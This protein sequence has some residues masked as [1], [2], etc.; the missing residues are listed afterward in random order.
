MAKLNG[1]CMCGEVQF[2][3][4]EDQLWS[5][6]CHCDDCRKQTASPFTGFFG[7]AEDDYQWTE[8]KAAVYHSTK[9]VNR[10]FCGKC[11]TPMAFESTNWP[12]EIHFYIA[13]VANGKTIKPQ[14]HV[15][16]KNHL[17]WAVVKDD[18]PKYVGA[19]GKSERYLDD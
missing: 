7:V 6:I 5:C 16:Y 8:K 10:Y 19:G 13:T 18:L 9:G 17:D 2:E 3:C 4:S 1:S 11:G 12:G 15:Y 14:M